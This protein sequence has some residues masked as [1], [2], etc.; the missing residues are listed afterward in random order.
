MMGVSFLMGIFLSSPFFIALFFWWLLLALL[1]VSRWASRALCNGRMREGWGIVALIG[2]P[3]YY[4]WLWASFISCLNAYA[5]LVL[6]LPLLVLS[7]LAFAH[8]VPVW[9]AWGKHTWQFW[10]VHI[11]AYVAVRLLSWILRITVLADFYS[12]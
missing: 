10:G 5:P 7:F 3:F 1:L 11:A 4:V 9:Q 8:A 2:S 12:G 6:D